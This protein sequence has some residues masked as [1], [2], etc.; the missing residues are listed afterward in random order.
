MC[1]FGTDLAASLKVNSAN[2][3]RM[4]LKYRKIHF[5]PLNFKN[6][7]SFKHLSFK[8]KQKLKKTPMI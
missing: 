7:F 8:T 5:K 1:K 4:H 2:N 3:T 6:L